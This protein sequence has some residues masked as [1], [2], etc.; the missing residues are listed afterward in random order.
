MHVVRDICD[1]VVIVNGGRVVADD[2][3]DRLVRLFRARTCRVTVADPLTDALLDRLRSVFEIVRPTDDRSVEIALR[4][5]DEFY[6]LA[7]ELRAA[8]CTIEAIDSVEPD[9]EEIF[10][11]IVRTGTR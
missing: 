8:S 4:D 6:R 5:G 1:R 3:I 9:L 2:T 11:N 10:L 7:D